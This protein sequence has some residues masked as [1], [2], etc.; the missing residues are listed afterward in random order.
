MTETYQTIEKRNIDQ[1]VLE[2]LIHEG[3]EEGALAFAEELNL[4]LEPPSTWQQ[5]ISPTND[6]NQMDTSYEVHQT[7]LQKDL[8]SVNKLSDLQFSNAILNYYT[9][10]NAHHDNTKIGNKI[11]PP[12]SRNTRNIKLTSGYSTISQRQEIKRLILNGEIT[13]AIT[14]ISRW[15]PIIL[16]SNN[17]LHFK[18]LRLNLIEM[19]RDHKFSSHSEADE[20]E[21]LNEILTFVRYNLIN[22]ISN[23]HKLLKELEFTMSLLCFRF[24]PSVKDLEDQKELPQEL[25]N[26]FN[27]NLRNQVFRLVNKEIL[28]MYEVKSLSDYN[29]GYENDEV[30]DDVKLKI[31][32]G[33]ETPSEG[34]DDGIY[35]S[36]S[37]PVVYTGPPY[38][39]FSFDDIANFKDDEFES[40]L[41]EMGEETRDWDQLVDLQS[42]Q[43]AAETSSE[44]Y[45]GE[46][47]LRKDTR[48]K[49]EDEVE[50][51]YGLALESKLEGLVKLFVLTE[52]NLQSLK[53]ISHHTFE[54]KESSSAL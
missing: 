5:S 12:L 46:R 30:L 11:Q 33:S 47:S 32:Y 16:D 8:Q 37:K 4:D 15:F 51:L 34:E 17:L 35:N 31:E 38:E 36:K 24:D 3:Y 13:S 41:E 40:D 21:F 48:V 23:S 26:F 49:N 25:R 43:P 9:N 44:V 18:L 42:I 27:I 2:Y 45:K 52:R 20:K 14:K 22:K 54:I 53:S 10:F 19:I 29:Q 7:T 1:L 28:D 39:S 6:Y 50:S